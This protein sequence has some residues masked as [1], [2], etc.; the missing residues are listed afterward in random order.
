MLAFTTVLYTVSS[1]VGVPFLTLFAW[2]SVWNFI[3]A[4]L[5]AF[6]DGA[7]LVKV[8]TRFTDD[9]F[10]LLIV[11]I[12]VM[13]AIGDPFSNVGILRYFDPDHP[14]HAKLEKTDPNY[15][16]LTTALFSTI[17]GFGTTAVIFFMRSFKFSP[18]CCNQN[19]RTALNDFA[20]I[21]SVVL[22]SVIANLI[23]PEIKTESLQVP[24]KIEPT[25]A[26]CDTTCTT[27]WPADCPDLADPARYRPWGVNLMDL[28]GK[29]WVAIMAAG[30]AL[31]AFFLTFLDNGITWHLIYCKQHTLY[32][33]AYNYDLILNALFNLVNGMIG[34]PWI[35]ATTVPCLIHLNALADRDR[36]G[37]FLHV[38]ETR[39]SYLFSHLILGCSLFVLNLL[40][41]I[42]LPVLY[43]VFL[44]MG[45][46]NL[47]SIEFWNRFLLFFMEPSKYPVNHMTKYMSRSQ[48]HK[49]TLFQLLF[50]FMIFTVQNIPQVA[51]VF[52]FMVFLCIPGRL[53]IMPRFLK[54][55]ELVLVDGDTDELEEWIRL[56]EESLKNAIAKPPGDDESESE[57]ESP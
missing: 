6:L 46:A 45:L 20:V 26:C 11:S 2:V 36:D 4:L 38:Q 12:F 16:Y 24:P 18:F 31:L 8:M 21:T 32:R 28:N 10:A 53:F 25:F 55:W 35:V 17:I 50:F 57:E 47:S 9:L 5:S 19:I 54:G 56:K 44:F 15:D 30:P 39:L 42:P 22:W 34:L 49:Y 14:S 3:Y 43:G 23:F 13:D 1:N 51:I 33:D 7:R 48:L 52:P 27:N 37:K 40:K 41:L 29:G